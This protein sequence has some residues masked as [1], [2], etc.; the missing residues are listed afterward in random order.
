[1][2][3]S[4]IAFLCVLTAGCTTAGTSRTEMRN[5]KP[6]AFVKDMGSGWNLGNAF[7]SIGEDETAW[8]NP[9][10]TKALI[11]AI[12]A[13]GFKT[14]RIPVTWRMH[15]GGAPEYTIEKAWMDRV[16]EVV[17]YAL[18]NDMYVILNTH[19]ENEWTIPTYA[20][21]DSVKGQLGK[22]WTQIAT[23]FR[24]YGD[25][26]IFEPLN[27]TRVE[28]GPREWSGG[29]EENRDCINQFQ[30]AAVDTIRATGG[31]NAT[32]MLLIAPHGAS[33]HP[34]AVKALIVPN[35]DPNT[36][37][38]IHNY[39][40]PDFCLMERDDWGSNED[41]QALK[42]SFKA[43]DEQFISQGKAVILGEWGGGGG[44]GGGST[45]HDNPQGPAEACR[46]FHARS[47]KIQHVPG[48][49]GITA[50]KNDFGLIDR[51][52]YAWFFPEIANLIIEES[53]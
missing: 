40:P 32:R 21:A 44:G 33:K 20:H 17:N 30:Q 48:L 38:S 3:N 35:N 34:D 26:L 45:N 7:D 52:T 23:R 24:D 28:G 12:A 37:I 2:R 42:N 53:R 9:S 5:L 51:N 13:R 46:I 41:I 36:I 15:M 31:N 25:H 19:H 4:I 16:E 43:I 8:G 18:S 11:D 29:T 10:P 50:G 27:E 49:V 39:F 6:I 22:V 1:M 14:I 47:K